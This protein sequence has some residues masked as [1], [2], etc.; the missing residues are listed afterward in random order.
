[1]A[2]RTSSWLAI[3][4]LS[5]ALLTTACTRSDATGPSDSPA[6]SLEVQGANN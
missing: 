1:M 3:A 6:T 2:R 5:L 4:S